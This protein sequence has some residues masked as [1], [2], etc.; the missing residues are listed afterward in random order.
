MVPYNVLLSF[1]TKKNWLSSGFLIQISGDLIFR[2]NMPNFYRLAGIFCFVI[3]VKV[4]VITVASR[5]IQEFFCQLMIDKRRIRHHM[6][7]V[8]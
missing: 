6:L 3:H 5:K 2:I 4:T 7:N 8:A 1:L